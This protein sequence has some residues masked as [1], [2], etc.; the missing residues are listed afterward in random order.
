LFAIMEGNFS[1]LRVKRIREKPKNDPP[2]PLV[3]WA[4]LMHLVL[5]ILKFRFLKVAS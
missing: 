4:N 2:Y 5:R 3:F 1:A